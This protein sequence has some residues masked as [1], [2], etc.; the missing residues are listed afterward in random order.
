MLEQVKLLTAQGRHLEAF[1]VAAGLPL[2]LAYL[3]ALGLEL[4]G[5]VFPACREIATADRLAP[6]TAGWLED[7]VSADSLLPPVL[8]DDDDGDAKDEVRKFR[9]AMI[10]A[11][12]RCARAILE[13]RDRVAWSTG[14]MAPD[15]A[16]E[17]AVRS[18]LPRGL[19]QDL[20]HTFLKDAGP[21][22]AAGSCDLTV[23]LVDGR[24]M[25]VSARLFLDL[26]LD[27]NGSLY[28]GPELTFTPRDQ[29]FQRA[30]GTARQYAE[31]IWPRSGPLADRDVRW[32]LV[33][34][35]GTTPARLE[36][37]SMGAAFAL[38]LMALMADP[39]AA[40]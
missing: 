11:S 18:A 13:H 28:A 34:S 16:D 5:L 23:L 30:E 10:R 26:M 8:I 33:R 20:T 15:L 9:S 39:A 21:R 1:Q 7:L 32:R 25:G 36:G 27:G 14:T 22:P 38:G 2:R 4:R 3:R 17:L 31:R 35:D 24:G 6:E 29:K 37:D 12:L 19:I 40:L